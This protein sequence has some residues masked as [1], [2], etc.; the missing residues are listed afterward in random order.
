[1]DKK[2]YA[3]EMIREAQVIVSKHKR[4]AYMMQNKTKK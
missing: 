1:M 2:S 4:V 3:I